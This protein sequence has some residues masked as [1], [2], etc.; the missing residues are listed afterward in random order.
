[1]NV[2]NKEQ[3]R[4]ALLL[5]HTFGTHSD[6]AGYGKSVLV[7]QWAN[8]FG[9]PIAWLSLDDSESELRT[10]LDYFL[11]TVDTVSPGAC[12]TTRELLATAALGPVWVQYHAA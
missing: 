1:M 10:F 3:K 4:N 9:N 12:A 8:Q 5:V 11:A 6:P 7:A 2:N